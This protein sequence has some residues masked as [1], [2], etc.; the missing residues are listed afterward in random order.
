[1][2]PVME[3][4]ITTESRHHH[5]HSCLTWNLDRDYDIRWTISSFFKAFR[6]NTIPCL[7]R[8]EV[9]GG[10]SCSFPST[11]TTTLAGTNCGR[12]GSKIGLSCGPSFLEKARRIAERVI[13]GG[14]AFTQQQNTESV[15]KKT[16]GC[17]LEKLWTVSNVMKRVIFDANVLSCDRS[18]EK[19]EASAQK[20]AATSNQP[21]MAMTES[22]LL[23]DR[24]RMLSCGWGITQIQLWECWKYSH[25]LDDASR[26]L[27]GYAL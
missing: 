16:R 9:K 13:N 6:R 2:G 26:Y 14:E 15:V 21:L 27:Q 20:V 25:T 3:P 11:V 10:H 8:Q 24:R 1:M 23:S 7:R 4:L 22:A 18:L 12:T 17:Y 5:Q 19:H